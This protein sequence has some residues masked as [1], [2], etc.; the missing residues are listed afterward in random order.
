MRTALCPP[1]PLPPPRTHISKPLPW[2]RPPPPSSITTP[3]PHHHHTT[4]KPAKETHTSKETHHRSAT[5]STTNPLDRRERLRVWVPICHDLHDADRRER[6]IRPRQV[7]QWPTA[8][9]AWV[10]L[11]RRSLGLA[12]LVANGGLRESKGRGRNH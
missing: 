2:Q 3:P 8:A 12:S 5:I 9:W 1:L 7:R 6:P 4:T 11:V 10:S